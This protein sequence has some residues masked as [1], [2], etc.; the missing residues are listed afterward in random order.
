MDFNIVGVPLEKLHLATIFVSYCMLWLHL[1][2]SISKTSMRFLKKLPKKSLKL[3]KSTL[4]IENSLLNSLNSKYSLSLP[5]TIAQYYRH[6]YHLHKKTSAIKG[7]L[8]Q[9]FFSTFS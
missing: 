6:E 9:I 4:L 8:I 1:V 5:V 7:F 3:L 2:S